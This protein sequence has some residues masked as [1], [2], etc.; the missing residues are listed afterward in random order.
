MT[1]LVLLET[2]IDRFGRLGFDGASTR[3]IAAAAKT[4]MSSITYHFGGK[5]GLYLAAADH[6]GRSIG[7][8]MQPHLDGIQADFPAN[9]EAA[10][11]AVQDLAVTLSRMMVDPASEPWVRFMLREQF[12]PS[13]A[14]DRIYEQSLGRICGVL[15]RLV[16]VARP[17]L[18]EAGCAATSI[19][20]LSQALILRAGRAT[21]CR[22]MGVAELE[23]PAFDTLL[24]TLR[25]NVRAILLPDGVLR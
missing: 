22:V 6:I 16:A 1:Q 9:R 18:D 13:E 21:V 25:A 2:A 14:F 4:T 11:L 10:V 15:A 23:G 8:K 24:V 20:I 7:E 3:A 17:D 5:E 19:Q 12:D